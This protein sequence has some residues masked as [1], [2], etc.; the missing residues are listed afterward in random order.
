MD[1]IEALFSNEQYQA[2]T[3]SNAGNSQALASKPPQAVLSRPK[4]ADMPPS[5]PSDQ[6]VQFL[7]LQAVATG[8]IEQAEPNPAIQQRLKNQYAKTLAAY[9]W[10]R[11]PDERH[12][13]AM[14]YLDEWLIDGYSQRI[15][16]DGI[17]D[18]TGAF[19][20][21]SWRL[22]PCDKPQTA[23]PEAP[24]Y[25]KATTRAATLPGIPLRRAI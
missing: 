4:P 6:A 9:H 23:A 1:A 2:E 22:I 16:L 19:R 13:T 17:C 14:N 5:Q 20:V 15:A 8:A 10:M 7:T 25:A 12:Q 11:E 24:A 3:Q 21:T 18:D